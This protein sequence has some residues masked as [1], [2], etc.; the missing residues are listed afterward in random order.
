VNLHSAQNLR[1]VS[2]TGELDVSFS[3]KKIAQHKARYSVSLRGY[4]LLAAGKSKLVKM[5]S[6]AVKN[7]LYGRKRLQIRTFE[8][9]VKADWSIDG[10]EKSALTPIQVY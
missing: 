2:I 9:R 3:T 4:G 8:R 10:Q 7:V 1:R 5:H 6:S